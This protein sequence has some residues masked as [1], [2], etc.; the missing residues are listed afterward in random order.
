MCRDVKSEG[1]LNLFCVVLLF[2]TIVGVKTGGSFKFVLFSSQPDG[3]NCS[4]MICVC[5]VG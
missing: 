4:R 3:S 1:E 2:S 5:D